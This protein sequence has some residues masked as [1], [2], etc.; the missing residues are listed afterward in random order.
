MRWSIKLWNNSYSSQAS[1]F[2][3]V[4]DFVNFINVIWWK[5]ASIV[6]FLNG[7]SFPTTFW[8]GDFTFSNPQTRKAFNGSWLK[9]KW[10]RI[11]NVPMENVHF[12]PTESGYE[13]FD[14]RNRYKMTRGI[15]QKTTVLKGWL[16]SYFLIIYSNG[17]IDNFIDLDKSFQSSQNTPLWFSDNRWLSIF[18]TFPGSRNSPTYLSAYLPAYLTNWTVRRT[19]CSDGEIISQNQHKL[20]R[21]I[22]TKEFSMGSTV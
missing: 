9:W 6:G 8:C 14:D 21:R 17:I 3:Q 10:L 20:T 1:K 15:Q 5:C 2:N 19:D 11:N 4:S 16:I 18:N 7:I 12:I 22:L 13:W